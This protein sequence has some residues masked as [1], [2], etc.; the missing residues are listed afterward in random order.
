MYLGLHLV[1][2]LLG[3][4]ADL[5][6]PAFAE[7][8]EFHPSRCFG[9]DGKVSAHSYVQAG[10]DARTALPHDD[11]TGLDQFAVVALDAQPFGLAI[12]AVLGAAAALLVC[13]G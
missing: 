9:E 10:V 5:P 12:A 4:H 8:L 1:L 7:G 11:R 3:Q 6:L 2:L 13:H